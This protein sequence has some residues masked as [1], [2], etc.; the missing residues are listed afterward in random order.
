V[1]GCNETIVIPVTS[2]RLLDGDALT[3]FD[4]P[5][6]SRPRPKFGAAVLTSETPRLNLG[7]VEAKKHGQGRKKV[8]VQK[9]QNQSASVG[10]VVVVAVCAV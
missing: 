2:F 9:A 7:R 8:E 5:S 1:L 3:S 6:R 10:V 4:T